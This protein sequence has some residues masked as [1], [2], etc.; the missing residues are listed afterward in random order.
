MQTKSEVIE[1]IKLN[2]HRIET[3]FGVTKI[4]VFG[5]IVRDSASAKSDIDIAV[6]MESENKFRNFMALERYLKKLLGKQIDL[7][8]ESALKPAVRDEIRKEIVYV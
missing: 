5:S 4:G 1:T 2:K 3:E 8:I 7:G 6:E